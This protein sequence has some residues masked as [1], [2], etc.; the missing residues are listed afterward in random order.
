MNINVKV[1]IPNKELA[2]IIEEIAKSVGNY[3]GI[4][5]ECIYASDI[6][7]YLNEFGEECIVEANL[8]NN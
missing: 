8:D 6:I 3:Y 5:D 1:K 7:N 4:E 2:D